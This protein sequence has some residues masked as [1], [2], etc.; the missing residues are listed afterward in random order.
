[1]GAD[2]ERA[3][4]VF[5]AVRGVVSVGAV[6]GVTVTVAVEAALVPPAPLQV[7]E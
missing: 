4:C 7:R 6:G 5:P 2:Q 3:T 1:M